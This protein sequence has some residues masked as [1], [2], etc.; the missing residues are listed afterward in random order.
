MNNY[1]VE[2]GGW[3]KKM[4]GTSHMDVAEDAA[5]EI[6]G[7]RVDSV[8]RDNLHKEDASEQRFYIVCSDNDHTFYT[9][10]SEA[11]FTV[12]SDG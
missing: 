1:I 12:K 6:L 8:V 10:K 11:W 7:G 2:V 9:L 4:Q 3:T 5:T